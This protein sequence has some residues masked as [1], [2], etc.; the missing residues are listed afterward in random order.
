MAGLDAGGESRAHKKGSGLRRPKKRLGIR[1]DMTPMVDIAFLLLIFYMVTTI[2]T[3]PKAME[4]NL[5]KEDKQE[6]KIAESNLLTIRIYKDGKFYENMGNKKPKEIDAKQVRNFL[7]EK[8]KANPE[9]LVTLIRIHKE[10]PYYK[11]VFLIDE[12]QVAELFI[13]ETIPAYSSR[14]A[15]DAWSEADDKEVEKALGGAE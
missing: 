8:N 6:I 5:P 1:I 11:M 12:I 15:L 4:V 10:A 7:I 3:T 14:F 9:K 2:F 13:K